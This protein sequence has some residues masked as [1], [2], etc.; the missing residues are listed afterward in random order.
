MIDAFGIFFVF[1]FRHPPSKRTN[2]IKYG[3]V[4]PFRCKW[5][6]LVE[7]WE[8]KVKQL[9]DIQDTKTIKMMDVTSVSGESP[10]PAPAFT[11]LRYNSCVVS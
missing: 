4:A 11:V 3:C 1:T 2:Y 10:N 9:E 5:Q 8:E 6:Q 7:E